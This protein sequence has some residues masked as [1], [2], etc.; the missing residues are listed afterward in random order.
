MYIKLMG[1]GSI[2]AEELSACALI[3]NRALLDCPNG[4]IKCLK[5]HK[6]NIK[7]I[8]L[9]IITHFHAD[10]YFDL[11]FLLLEQGMHN[12][13]IK[14]FV[15]IGP[16]GLQTK[17]YTLFDIAYPELWEKVR[18]NS[19]LKLIEIDSESNSISCD[20]Y[21]VTPY[22]VSHNNYEAY[23]YTIS[24]GKSVVGFTGDT[25][26]CPNVEEIIRKSRLSFVDMSFEKNSKAHMGFNN[27]NDLKQK[28][29]R[30]H[31]IIPTHMSADARAAYEQIYGDAPKDG[32]EYYI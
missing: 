27:V 6:V 29:I 10:H 31:K 16:K 14:N 28:Y 12:V 25:L 21:L 15:I 5:R 23:G 1:T 3:D 4:L 9:C 22:K 20:G 17:L 24:D 32:A 8:N 13:R 11:P 7:N 19:K 2:W 18:N 26:Y 30:D